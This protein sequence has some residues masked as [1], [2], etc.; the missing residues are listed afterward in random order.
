[1][2]WR[3]LRAI[4]T[5]LGGVFDLK[6]LAFPFSAPVLHGGSDSRQRAVRALFQLGDSP[7]RA[8]FSPASPSVSPASGG[9]EW[10]GVSDYASTITTTRR[11]WA[12]PALVVLGATGDSSP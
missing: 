3:S 6:L 1:M 9:K 12:R 2:V 4:L 8:P 7:A 11:F 10:L 5:V